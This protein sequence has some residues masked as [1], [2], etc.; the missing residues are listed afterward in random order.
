MKKTLYTILIFVL[1][2]AF[3]FG[4]AGNEQAK[5]D[6]GKVTHIPPG[7][8]LPAGK[9]QAPGPKVEHT[10][11]GQKLPAGTAQQPGPKEEHIPPGSLKQDSK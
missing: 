3:A 7:V 8:L 11:P 10:P 5:P 6:N 1:P 2:I 4:Q 9:T